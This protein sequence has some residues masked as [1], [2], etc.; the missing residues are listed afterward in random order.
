MNTE[1]LPTIESNRPAEGEVTHNR[2]IFRQCL[3]RT[4]FKTGISPNKAFSDTALR[5][6]EKLLFFIYL[7]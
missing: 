4:C 7:P 3:S 5:I 6:F 2:E 1:I